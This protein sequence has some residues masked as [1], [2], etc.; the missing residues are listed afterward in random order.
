VTDPSAG[1]VRDQGPGPTG[2]PTP[3]TPSPP[4][5]AVSDR[6]TKLARRF[7]E[8]LVAEAVEAG[9]ESGPAA[10]EPVVDWRAIWASAQGVSSPD[11]AA[12]RIVLAAGRVA[13]TISGTAVLV[14]G[15][16]RSGLGSAPV[17]TEPPPSVSERLAGRPPHSPPAPAPAPA[18]VPAP[19]PWAVA[20]RPP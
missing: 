15:A 3:V 2:S 16:P 17:G 4:S 13:R 19:P 10:V 12:G 20:P 6:A 7:A 9:R 1:D 5:T 18:P 8:Q 14:E 11:R